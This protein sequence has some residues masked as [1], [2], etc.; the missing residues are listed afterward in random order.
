VIAARGVTVRVGRA[1]LV[2]RVDLD[3]AAGELLA[4]VGP[5][6][7]GK[8]TLLAALS[9]DRT[10]TEGRA[11]IAGVDVSS[12]PPRGLAWLRAVLPQAA[13]LEASF[14]A[15]E[16]VMLGQIDPIGDERLRRVRALRRL[17]E[18]ELGRLA[19]RAYPS[20]SGGEKQRVQ[21]ARVLE[22]L[23]DGGGRALFLDEPTAALDPRHQHVVLGLARAAAARGHAV[24]AV[25]HDLSL[26]S[27]WA[28]RIGLLHR[29]ALIGCGA[30]ADVLRRD[31]LRRAFAVDFDLVAH[32][33]GRGLL[34]AAAPPGAP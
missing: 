16:V 9:G 6:G 19:G 32:P 26:A 33:G 14:T 20:L 13:A 34:V 3:V 5:N 4:L 15:L 28:D 29:G 11:L 12:A 27:R 7:A 10:M 21:L 23:G 8:S 1:T 2:D 22:Q 24:V 25:L 31:L 30:P 18:V 17:E